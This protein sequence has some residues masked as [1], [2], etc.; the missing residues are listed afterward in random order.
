MKEYFVPLTLAVA[1]GVA[2]CNRG[3]P[4]ATPTPGVTYEPTTTPTWGP[5][6]VI[7]TR[8][9]STLVPPPTETPKSLSPNAIFGGEIDHHSGTGPLAAIRADMIRQGYGS[10]E[11]GDDW[12]YQVYR[13]NGQVETYESLE[14]LILA[15]A[16]W[17]TT[18]IGGE[19]A[20]THTDGTC[21]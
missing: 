20:I 15:Y 11:F 7:P 2:G 16:G 14:E 3:D 12:C 18:A 19:H 6:P 9:V 8:P 1:V 21:E 17:G 4:Y 13:P 10:L 5:P